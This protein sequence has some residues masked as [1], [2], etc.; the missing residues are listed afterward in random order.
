M[1]FGPAPICM[2]CKHY[3]REDF[4]KFSCKAFPGGIPRVILD[5]E[6]DHTIPLTSQK[7]DIIFE[8]KGT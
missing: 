8:K 7:N 4:D 2:D 5:H 6:N 1:T 3:N